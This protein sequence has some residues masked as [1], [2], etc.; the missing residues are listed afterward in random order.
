MIK[1]SKQLEKRVTYSGCVCLDVNTAYRWRWPMI[2]NGMLT[3]N[4]FFFPFFYHNDPIITSLLHITVNTLYTR[5]P[6]IFVH[7][8]FGIRVYKLLAFLTVNQCV[9][10]YSQINKYTLINSNA[11]VN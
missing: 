11:Q 8:T 9:S 3:I 2:E 1:D 6:I 7:F 5:L 4:V 10:I